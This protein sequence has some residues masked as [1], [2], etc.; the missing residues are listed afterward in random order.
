MLRNYSFF[1]SLGEIQ[2]GF[3]QMLSSSLVFSIISPN[4]AISHVTGMKED[5]LRIICNC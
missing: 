1:N 2:D 4:I 5:G 3:D